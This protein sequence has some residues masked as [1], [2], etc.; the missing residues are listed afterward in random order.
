M[1]ILSSLVHAYNGLEGAP[2]FGFSSEKIS[3]LIALDEAGV[4]VGLPH[5]LRGEDKKRTPRQ[6]FVPQAIKRT[7]G[8][9]P[10]FLWDK[11]SY[12]LGVTAGEGKRT[13]D[14]HA[15]FVDRHIVDLGGADDPG[16]VAL[17]GFLKTWTPERFVE[18]GWPQ[19]MKDQNVVFALES[20]RR[21]DIRIHDRPAARALWARLS[22]SGDKSEA[23]C[24]VSGDRAPVARLHPAIKGV[25]GAQSS[26][27]SIVS[28]N[29]DAF[30]S[31]GHEQGDNAQ[32]SEAAAFAYTTVLNRFL[33]RDSG[34]RIQIGDASTVFW[35]DASEAD[36]E[37]EAENIFAG[38]FEGSAPEEATID[39]KAQ[40]A[41]VGTRLAQIKAG[42]PL[43]KVAP[44]LADGVRFY[45]LGLAPNAARLS[46]RF[47]YDKD[48]G[49]LAENYRRYVEDMRLE[50]PPR[51]GSP[52]LWRY[53]VETA[54]LGKRENVPPNL[55]GEWMRSI[56]AGTPYPLTLLSNVLM[57][58]RS[59]QD[60]NTLRVSML[61]AIIVRNFS[62]EDTPV[63]LQPDYPN[64]G[65]RL[66]RLF[67]VYERI[68]TDALGGKVNATVKDKFYGAA[69]AQPRKV[70]SLLER[71]SANH[72]SK[73]GKQSPGRKVN[74]EKLVGEIMG[75][76]DP[77][78]DPFPAS[79]SAEDQAL[80]GLGYYHQR[81][82]FFKSHKDDTASEETAK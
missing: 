37:R 66:G 69:S 9:A 19:E 10:N 50:P 51:D 33:E 42:E 43:S 35:A 34:H 7:A 1:S 24:L 16:L 28:F 29:L 56:L 30:T 65:Y 36:K 58:L 32:V 79:L 12:V 73:L 52:P 14:E 59:D 55:A 49:T 77:A 5:D 40:A 25:W 78:A 2:P 39:E 67:A 71:G 26:G 8:I 20:E 74:L 72:L 11:S 68:Q 80:F 27:A 61:K 15:A 38:L 76:M 44:E 62:R 3:F 81:N 53:L 13:T 70:F 63:A 46:I 41:L 21:R 31:Y 60:V 57:R 22:A 64:K 47:Y 82:D 45:V 17:V 75:A 6:L 54:V 4:P 48:F 18:L 23:I